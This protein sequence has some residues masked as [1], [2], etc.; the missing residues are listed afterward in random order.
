MQLLLAILV[1]TLFSG[2]NGFFSADNDPY[3]KDR[4]PQQKYANKVLLP[5]YEVCAADYVAPGYDLQEARNR[6][7]SDESREFEV[8]QLMK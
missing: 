2:I 3:R 7:V 1:L 4:P 8:I 6:D 5:V